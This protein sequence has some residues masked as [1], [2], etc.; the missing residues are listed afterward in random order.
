MALEGVAVRTPMGSQGLHG[1]DGAG[2]EQ[3]HRNNELEDDACP[4]QHSHVRP[5][6]AQVHVEANEE[7]DRHDDAQ[8]RSEGGAGQIDRIP[9]EWHDVRQ[10]PC[11]HEGGQNG[12]P[13]DCPGNA[14]RLGLPF[15]R[16]AEVVHDGVAEDDGL[17]QVR[18]DHVDEQ[19]KPRYPDA[20]VEGEVLAEQAGDLVAEEV[21]AARAGEHEGRKLEGGGDANVGLRELGWVLHLRHDLDQ[22]ELRSHREGEGAEA[23]QGP[24]PSDVGHRLPIG[25]LGKDILHAEEGVVRQRGDDGPA[26]GPNIQ[27]DQSLEVAQ[28][29]RHQQEGQDQGAAEQRPHWQTHPRVEEHDPQSLAGAEHVDAQHGEQNAQLA[30]VG[31][32]ENNSALPRRRVR[33]GRANEVAIGVDVPG[34]AVVHVNLPHQQRH[35]HVGGEGEREHHGAQRPT[36]LCDSARHAEDPGAD[37]VCDNDGGGDPSI[38]VGMARQRG[39]TTLRAVRLGTHVVGVGGHLRRRRGCWPATGKPGTQGREVSDEA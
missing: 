10:E 24:V 26:E 16:K 17:D 37:D 20:A 34:R 9:E 5:L 28:A 12:D 32:H 22:H 8:E 18:D 30:H 27:P 36:E 2:E 19:A 13:P 7:Q 6:V 39:P 38:V 1:G 15:G 4:L 29:L 23:A 14:G 31:R 35:V 11:R 33:E 3:D 21:V 25:A